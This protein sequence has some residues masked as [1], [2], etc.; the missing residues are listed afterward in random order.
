MKK[1]L[2]DASGESYSTVLN[3]SEFNA[4]D[5]HDYCFVKNGSAWELFVDGDFQVNCSAGGVSQHIGMYVFFAAAG[6]WAEFDDFR[7]RNYCY[8]TPEF[9]S[10]E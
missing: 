3:G 10:R 4:S 6:H 9:G 7:M 2:R 1:G 8:P 5:W